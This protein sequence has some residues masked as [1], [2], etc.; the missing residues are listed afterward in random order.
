MEGQIVFMVIIDIFI[1]I[2]IV[3]T[4]FNF[5]IRKLISK[6]GFEFIKTKR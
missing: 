6:I 3:I 4:Y 1:E 2:Y 5:V